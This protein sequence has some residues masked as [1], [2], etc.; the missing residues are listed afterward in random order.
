MEKIKYKECFGDVFSLGRALLFGRWGA[1]LKPFRDLNS[2]PDHGMLRQRTE[3][4]G[5]QGGG[6]LKDICSVSLRSK[7]K[8]LPAKMPSQFLQL[9]SCWDAV[10][11]DR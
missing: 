2:Y 9:L 8:L 5:Q 7:N 10:A 4:G 11:I 3:S 1:Y 6:V